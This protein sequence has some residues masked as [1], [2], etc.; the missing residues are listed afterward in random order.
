MLPG[1]HETH[2]C[3]VFG[4]TALL[5]V[6]LNPTPAQTASGCGLSLDELLLLKESG[7]AIS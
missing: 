4:V 2:G 5:A 7:V 1:I 6:S 3:K